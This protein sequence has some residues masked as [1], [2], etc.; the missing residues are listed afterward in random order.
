[1]TKVGIDFI[2]KIGYARGMEKATEIDSG[3]RNG[4]AENVS[5]A[6]GCA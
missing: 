6:H 5:P 4:T 3:G 2:D 1:M